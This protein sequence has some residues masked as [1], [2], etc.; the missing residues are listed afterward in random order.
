MS[1]H[2]NAILLLTLTPAN[3]S[4][5][6]MRAIL[7]EPEG[8]TED[9]ETDVRIGNAN[10]HSVVMESNYDEQW[11]LSAKEGDLLF[12]CMI[13]YGYGESIPWG[14]L[15]S[16]KLELEEWAKKTCELHNCTY[17]ISVGANYW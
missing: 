13:T 6:T 12:F 16:Q 2:P 14:K 9:T 1:T 15:E 8:G 3:T 10:Y 17:A 11:Q 5:A 4:R 7:S